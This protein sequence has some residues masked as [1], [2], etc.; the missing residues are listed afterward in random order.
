[1][2][3][4]EKI[5]VNSVKALT[6]L[7]FKT[8]LCILAVKA[9]CYFEPSMEATDSNRVE[10]TLDHLKSHFLDRLAALSVREKDY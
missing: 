6:N 8:N 1:M 5:E 7:Q 9:P 3:S 10:T 2:A 4:L